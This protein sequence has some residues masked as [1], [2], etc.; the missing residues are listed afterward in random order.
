ML[1]PKFHFV[2]RKVAPLSVLV[3]TVFEDFHV[4]NSK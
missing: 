4:N 1:M 2:A 3:V